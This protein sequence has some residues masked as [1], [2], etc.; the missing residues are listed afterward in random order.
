MYGA[1][2][3]ESGTDPNENKA[4]VFGGFLGSVEEWE[5]ASDAWDFATS[6]KV[7]KHKNS[8]DA[9]DLDLARTIAK[10]NLRG[11]CIGVPHSWFTYRDAKASKGV[12]GTRAYDWG[13]GTATTGVLDYLEAEYPDNE[14]VDF[15]FD[16]RSELR[17]C[18]STYYETKNHPLFAQRLR[19]A[20][21]CSSGTDDEI[22]ALQMADLLAGELCE[23][24]N[25]RVKSDVLNVIRENNKIVQ[26]HC[27]PPGRLPNTLR[28]GKLAHAVQAEAANFLRRSKK[29]SPD[30]FTRPEAISADFN[31]LLE[32]FSYFWLEWERHLQQAKDDTDYQEF[33]KRYYSTDGNNEE[34]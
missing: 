2:F 12:L 7:Y 21:E 17:A 19:R 9:K 27:T 33:L 3:D 26:I 32:H 6:G 14:K 34:D 24:L 5:R 30:K 22:A 15:V 11:I 16:E 31:E 13:F 10:F 1:F 29:Q 20:G 25:T 8:D 18:I 4:L 23:N 28:M